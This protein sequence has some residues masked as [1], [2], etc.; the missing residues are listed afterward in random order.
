MLQAPS[1]SAEGAARRAEH[2]QTLRSKVARV[3]W[4]PYGFCYAKAI[5]WLGANFGSYAPGSVSAAKLLRSKSQA[6]QTLAEQEGAC[7]CR[8]RW[9]STLRRALAPLLAQSP[10][11]Q[12]LARTRSKRA[13]PALNKSVAASSGRVRPIA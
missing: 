3:F 11:V 12:V 13:A 7:S 6:G 2:G 4:A 10:I 1:C 5:L 8:P 9:G